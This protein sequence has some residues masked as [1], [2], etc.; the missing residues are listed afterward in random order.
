MGRPYESLMR[1]DYTYAAII[2][3]DDRAGLAAYLEHP[4]HEQ[5]GAQVFDAF[6]EALICDFELQDGAVELAALRSITQ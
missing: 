6:E 1:V 4:S 2:E 3:F 5:L